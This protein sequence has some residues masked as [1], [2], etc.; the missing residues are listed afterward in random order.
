MRASQ[1]VG[2]SHMVSLYSFGG[3]L[4]LRSV[5]QR[6]VAAYI[7]TGVKGGFAPT[8]HNMRVCKLACKHAYLCRLSPER[9]FDT[10]IYKTRRQVPADVKCPVKNTG[11]TIMG[12]AFVER[13]ANQKSQIP[14]Q[15]HTLKLLNRL[16]MG[17]PDNP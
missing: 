6:Y 11:K 1:L 5:T 2:A 8:G 17:V 7:D 9:A 4:P 16:W 13:H 10:H 14:K 15:W 12:W 3:T